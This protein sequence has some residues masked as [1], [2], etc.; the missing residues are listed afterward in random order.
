MKL[1]VLICTLDEGI[2]RVPDILLPP[3]DNVAYVV[4]MQYTREDYQQ[5]IPAELQARPD[6]RIVTLQGKGLSRNRNNALQAAQG[7]IALIA[8]D[9]VRY[10]DAYFDRVIK[11]FEENENVDIAQFKI[12]ALDGGYIKDYPAYSYTY[13]H[14]PRGMYVSSIEIAVRT[15][16][17]RDKIH[18]DERFGLGSPYFICGEEEVLFYNAYQQ[19]LTITYYPWFVVETTSDSTGSRTYS[20]ERVMMAKGAINYYLHGAWAWLRMLKFALH[21]ALTG[22]GSLGKLLRATFKGINYYKKVVRYEDSVG[23]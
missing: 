20:D 21:G 4:S 2:A 1:D 7:D 3:R 9:D 19:G 8:D 10:C 14:V 16:T 6:V 5:L 17:T 11:A 23:R 15:A 22:R 18:F 13:P 12:K